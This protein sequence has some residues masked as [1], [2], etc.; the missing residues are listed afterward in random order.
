MTN[1]N[2]EFVIQ[3]YIAKVANESIQLALGNSDM[4]DIEG[5]INKAHKLFDMQ[6]MS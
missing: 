6:E 2:E 5:L 3:A 4:T 1:P